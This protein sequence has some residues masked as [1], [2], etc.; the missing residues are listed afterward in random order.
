MCSRSSFLGFFLLL[1]FYGRVKPNS[2]PCTEFC[3]FIGPGHK[4]GHVYRELQPTCADARARKDAGCMPR[5]IIYIFCGMSRYLIPSQLRKSLQSVHLY[6]QYRIKNNADFAIRQRKTKI[7]MFQ[8]NKRQISR[9][10]RQQA[11]LTKS[12]KQIR[13]VIIIAQSARPRA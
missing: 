3:V 7:Y 11:M 6:D 8:F 9:W 2:K 13:C 10:F 12:T 4:P 1:F 5:D